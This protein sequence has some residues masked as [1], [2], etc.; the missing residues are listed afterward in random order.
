MIPT[1]RGLSEL[2]QGTEKVLPL[3][4]ERATCL[5]WINAVAQPVTVGEEK[6]LGLENPTW[7]LLI[8]Q[9]FGVMRRRQALQKRTKTRKATM[10]K[11]VT[12]KSRM[13]DIDSEKHQNCVL[14][15]R[16][17]VYGDL[18]FEGKAVTLASWVGKRGEK[19]AK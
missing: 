9:R 18:C 6:G 12:L 7:K 3:K 2:P 14:K 8:I 17:T 19:S 16:A 15:R 1:A 11:R 10:R 5:G 4:S 13:S